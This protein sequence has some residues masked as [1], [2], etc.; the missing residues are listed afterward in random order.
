MMLRN[1]TKERKES[2]SEF[3]WIWDDDD[4]IEFQISLFYFFMMNS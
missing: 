3:P 1:R 2:R 4:G